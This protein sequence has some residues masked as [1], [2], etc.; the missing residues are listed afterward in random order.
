MLPV[1]LDLQDFMVIP[2]RKTK[3]TTLFL[4]VAFAWLNILSQ[5]AIGGQAQDLRSSSPPHPLPSTDGRSPPLVLPAVGSIDV[6]ARCSQ[7]QIMKDERKQRDWMCTDIVGTLAGLAL[8]EAC[9]Q[10]CWKGKS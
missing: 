9:F 8:S 4:P 6:E 1:R 7:G 10:P 5:L 3:S 2:P